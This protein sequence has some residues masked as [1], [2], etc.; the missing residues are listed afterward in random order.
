MAMILRMKGGAADGV[1]SRSGRLTGRVGVLSYVLM[2]VVALT[3]AAC[4]ERPEE[5]SR[6]EAARKPV[7]TAPADTEEPAATQP[8]E[9][10]EGVDP[11]ELSAYDPNP[12]YPVQLVVRDPEKDDQPGWL[13][14]TELAE[15]AALGG[16]RGSFPEPNRIYVDTHDVQRLR[17]HLGQLP[18]EANRRIILQIDGHGIELRRG[19]AYIDLERRHTGVWEVIPRPDGG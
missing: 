18:I 9:E 1:E 8:A 16:T 10:P 6:D 7:A 2:G 17:L 19:R 5:R 12:P 11:A 14:I 15:G 4:S 3:A 13:R